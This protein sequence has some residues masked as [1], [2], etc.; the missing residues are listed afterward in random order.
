[1]TRRIAKNDSD[2][3]KLKAKLGNENFLRNAPP[4]V[5]AADQARVAEFEA[6]NTS[7]A[8]QLARVRRL[9]GG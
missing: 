9:D 8:A 4:A 2:I 3:G 5:V 1:M 7:L 6:Q